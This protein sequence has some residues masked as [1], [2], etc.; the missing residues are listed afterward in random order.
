MK[1]NGRG[2]HK[3]CLWTVLT[4]LYVGFIFSN[5]MKPA[6]ISSEDSGTALRLLQNFLAAGG[7]DSGGITEHLIRKSAHFAEYAVL[8]SLLF[9]CF[10]AY[11]LPFGRRMSLQVILGFFVPFADETI[12]LFVPGRSGQ[13]SDVW[14]DCAGAA[15]GTVCFLTALWL[16][17]RRRK[18]KNGK[19]LQDSS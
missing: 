17:E 5:S 15:F 4:A 13:L 8:G 11:G 7:I 16:V 10:K 18:I 9:C 6:A 14:L 19:K 1:R 2:F 12:Q 3:T